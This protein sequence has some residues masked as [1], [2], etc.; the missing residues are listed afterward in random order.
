M[1]REVDD[2]WSTLPMAGVK[3]QPQQQSAVFRPTHNFVSI[4]NS[5]RTNDTYSRL[6]TAL[7]TLQQ[8][9][10]L[11]PDAPNNGSRQKQALLRR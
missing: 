9:A 6:L 5:D 7:Y 3:A 8:R 11:N 10:N 4:S 1:N 2:E